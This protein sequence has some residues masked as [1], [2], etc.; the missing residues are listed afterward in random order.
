M[1]LFLSYSRQNEEAAKQL[2]SELRSKGTVS[3]TNCVRQ[4]FC[5]TEIGFPKAIVL[6]HRINL[7]WGLHWQGM[8]AQIQQIAK[9]AEWSFPDAPLRGVFGR[10][11][12]YAGI[13]GWN[14]FEPWLSRIE[15]F[16]ESSLW[17]L[18]DQIPPEWYGSAVD[19]L[20]RLLTQLLERRSRVRELILSFKNSS[21]N[22]FPNW[23]GFVA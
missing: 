15:S 4:P 10:N 17:P 5:R 2:Y 22:P 8:Q 18:V 12:V 7:F 19:E 6:A 11:D 3:E 14:S 9:N 23:S 21:R 16:P 20:E 1:N 13:T